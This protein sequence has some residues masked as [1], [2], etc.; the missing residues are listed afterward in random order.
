MV[1]DTLIKNPNQYHYTKVNH[2][3]NAKIQLPKKQ[4]NTNPKTEKNNKPHQTP[5]I[6]IQ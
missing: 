6:T 3:H 1:T 2:R 4:Y 5:T